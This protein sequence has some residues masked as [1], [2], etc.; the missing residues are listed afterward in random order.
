MTG[1]SGFIGSYLCPVLSEAGAIIAGNSFRASSTLPE[2][3]HTQHQY[4]L[5][6][7]SACNRLVAESEPDI[8][9]NLSSVV[10]GARDASLI[11]PMF[12]SNLCGAVNLMHAATECGVARVINAGSLEEPVN[13]YVPSSPYA[14]SK[15]AARIYAELYRKMSSVEIGHVRIGMVYGPKTRDLTKLVSYVSLELL[16]GRAPRLTSGDRKADWIYVKDV[17]EGIAALANCDQL[18]EHDLT[19]GTGRLTSVKDVV[20]QLISV[21]GTDIRAEFGAVPE[22]ADEMA[23]AADAELMYRS[24]DWKSRYTLLEGLTE[25]LNWYKESLR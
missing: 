23:V 21:S 5:R 18:P 13:D 1:A 2:C 19:L 17:A 4:D 10:I 20:E 25:T 11:Q 22:R 24:I 14:A 12:Q 7:P 9:I 3:V 16:N 15:A 6:E 8:I